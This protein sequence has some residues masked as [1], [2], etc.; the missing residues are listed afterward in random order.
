MA[1][2]AVYLPDGSD[3]PWT[4]QNKKILRARRYWRE[5]VLP[6][7][8]WLQRR[9]PW[10]QSTERFMYYELRGNGTAGSAAVAAVAASTG[11]V[12][13]ASG[14]GCQGS[15]GGCGGGGS[16]EVIG[17]APA[18]LVA[19]ENGLG[20]KGKH[21]LYG[22]TP[23]P[24]E[25]VHYTCTTQTEAARIWPLRLFGH[26]HA[27]AVD[28]E[29]PPPSSSVGAAAIVGTT[30]ATSTSTNAAPTDTTASPR[31]TAAAPPLLALE[32]GTFAT[33]LPPHSWGRLNVAHAMLGALSALS[34]RQAVAPATNCSGV[35]GRRT[36]SPSARR[37]RGRGAH[38]HAE[39]AMSSRCFWHVHSPHG[40]RCVLRIG[41]CEGLATPTEGADADA[42]VRAAAA[43]PPVVTIDLRTPPEALTS[44]SA[45]SG[46]ASA[47]G[48]RASAPMPNAVDEL[49]SH[50]TARLVYLRVLWPVEASASGMASDRTGEGT[51]ERLGSGRHERSFLDRIQR[52]VS[53]PRLRQAL[54]SFRKRCADMTSG[55]ACN[56]ICS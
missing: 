14:S 50:A 23:P 46:A 4:L 54:R 22:A 18:W 44:S 53:E 7:P 52:T 13:G 41:H 51:E 29:V 19:M 1:S 45:A 38:A 5:G 26:W 42:A 2:H 28:A 20:L 17:L 10:G 34:G 30:R 12:D 32:G 49:L 3:T 47:A 6:T 40:V 15:G 9:A 31:P 25:L 55:P 36:I 16:G 37:S 43:V 24:A 11:Y 56:N 48:A 21:W 8:T 35:G 33:P 39:P 27:A